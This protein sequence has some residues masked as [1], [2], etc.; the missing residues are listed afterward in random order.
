MKHCSG[1]R[2]IFCLIVLIIISLGLL[3]TSSTAIGATLKLRIT[4]DN[5]APA[6]GNF[7]TPVWFGFH[8]GSFDLYDPGAAASSA[9]E[10]L[11]EDGNAGPISAAFLASGAGNVDGVITG[12][13]SP[14]FAPGDIKTTTLDIDGSLSANRYFSY[15]SMVIPS[16]DAFIANGDPFA[17][18]IFDTSG[19]FLGADFFVTG[20][21]VLDAG[22]E[23]NDELPANT[24]FFG[25][26][27][28]NTGVDE[29]GVVQIHPGFNPTGSGGILDDP[30]FAN[31]DFTRTGYP[32]AQVRV[33]VVPLPSAILL[34][35]S[36]VVA[37]LGLRRKFRG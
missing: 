2:K 25:Q 4:I 30:Q 3:L 13:V 1:D 36:G 28:P 7:L 19:T 24:A 26:M 32:I 14:P 29:F 21:Q 15:A 33:E 6:G 10:R 37:L 17:V 16:N 12:P 34:F 8:D 23:V 31:A 18:E 22:T 27:T 9:L 35:F 11:A 20:A 5:L